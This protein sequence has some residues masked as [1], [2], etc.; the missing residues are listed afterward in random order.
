M[1]FKA[2]IR[3]VERAVR[4]RKITEGYICDVDTHAAPNRGRNFQV[5]F[6]HHFDGETICIANYHLSRFG[7]AR[8]NPALLE[9]RLVL[10]TGKEDTK[11]MGDCNVDARRYRVENRHRLFGVCV[12]LLV[13]FVWTAACSAK[14]RVASVQKGSRILALTANM[15]AAGNYDK[16]FAESLKAGNETMVVPQDWNELET[17]PGTYGKGKNLLAIANFYYPAQNI[18]VH[19]IIRPIHTTRKVVPADL[20]D[21]PLDHPPTI[22][23]FKKLLDWV[24]TQI[25]KVTLTSM[26]IGS[27]VDLT[28]WGNAQKWEE[29]T[30]FYAAVTPYARK[31]FPGTLISCE[32][33]Y[34]AFSGPD[35]PRVRKLHQH[36]DV[37]GVSYYPMKRKLRG[38]REPRSV[39]ADFDR[40]VNAIPKKPIIY[41]QIGYP[42][43]AA[44]GSSEK[45][46]AS[47]IVEAFRAWDKHADRIRMLNF[48]WMHET[49]KHGLDHYT[50]YYQYDT[51]D[52]RSFLGSLGL[53]SWE[54][55]P[56]LAWHAFIKEAKA[57]GFG[58]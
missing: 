50:K 32:T 12:C 18:P 43:S 27:E 15:G 10:R 8:R 41:Y 14:P 56:K 42:S 22:E 57:R 54:G 25:P 4:V 6:D 19:L 11:T 23:R 58:K 35:L 48:E 37:I 51:P 21:K 31:K 26:V 47:F 49:P 29:W 9:S 55:K 17:T 28:M 7:P 36:S 44:L 46:Q 38:V 40:V 33:S 45:H 3:G 5:R 30:R 1:P 2:F 39:H 34:S 52:F 53:Q 13:G 16:I 24:A 20:M